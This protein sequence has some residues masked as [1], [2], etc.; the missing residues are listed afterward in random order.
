MVSLDEQVWVSSRA[1]MDPDH[2]AVLRS[3][4][5]VVG[6]M[7]LGHLRPEEVGAT[8]MQ[9]FC[10]NSYTDHMKGVQYV[11]GLAGLLD[12]TSWDPAFVKYVVGGLRRMGLTSHQEVFEG[13]VRLIEKIGIPW[14][15]KILRGNVQFA[16]NPDFQSLKHLVA[17]RDEA[18]A[19]ANA[20]QNL[21]EHLANWLRDFPGT[22]RHNAEDLRAMV[23]QRISLITDRASREAEDWT[24][25]CEVAA[26]QLGLELQ[27]VERSEVLPG[28]IIIHF[29]ASQKQLRF[30]SEEGD[31][32]RLLDATTDVELLAGKRSTLAANL[33]LRI[34][35]TSIME[36][37]AL[38]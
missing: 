1:A 9:V 5:A 28:C 30:V 24:G 29:S 21:S 31:H 25:I 4:S 8:A 18:F 27:R 14:L 23:D 34:C 37:D 20:K 19:K 26:R 16:S 33:P 32:F 6:A 22:E 38:R 13:H 17:P 36:F 15:H 2:R 3:Q 10:I 11:R 7:L 35:W 12:K